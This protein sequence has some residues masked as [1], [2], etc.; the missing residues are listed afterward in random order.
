MEKGEKEGSN[1][2]RR[3]A[4]PRPMVSVVSAQHP[5]DALEN[6][7]RKILQYQSHG[8]SLPVLVKEK[9][10]KKE[11][12]RHTGEKRCKFTHMTASSEGVGVLH[13]MRVHG[14]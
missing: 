8:G 2:G 13:Y 9:K 11:G 6:R 14:G 10:K 3:R 12:K 4:T 7:G 1:D 5:N